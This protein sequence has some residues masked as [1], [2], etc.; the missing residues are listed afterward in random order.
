[1]DTKTPGTLANKLL[2]AL[3]RA[4]N[5][6]L[7]SHLTVVPLVQGTVL[8][9]A[10]QEVDHVFFPLSGMVSMLA[11]L[12]NG[13]A[14]ETATIGREGV[15]GA[16]AGLGLHKSRVRAVIQLASS[17]AR[18]PSSEFRKATANS[19]AIS[20]LCIRYNEVLLAQA[21]VTAA[22]NI[23]HPV[24]ARFCRWLLQSRDRA[25]SE[26]VPLT[27]EFLSE[28]L[29]V[30]RTSVTEVAVKMQEAGAISYSR[31]IIKIINREKLREISCECYDTLREDA[32]H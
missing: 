10:D 24:E 3:P 5:E 12:K 2:A 16:M 31:G 32:P 11:V 29:G 6:A 25:D 15:V 20:N 1:M 7:Q 18:I 30:R 14:V 19:P 27:Q 28:M 9:E 4:D 22:C 13:N 8:F 26:T 17:V 23:S 21:R